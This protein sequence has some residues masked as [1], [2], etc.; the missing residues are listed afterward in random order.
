MDMFEEYEAE[1]L[2]A[3]NTPEALAE[4]ARSAARSKIR[5]EEAHRRGVELGWFDEDGNSLLPED[6]EDE[7]EEDEI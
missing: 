7:N 6:P 3:M 1:R 5:V 4:E 2:R